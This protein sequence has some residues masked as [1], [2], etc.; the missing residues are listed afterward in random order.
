MVVCLSSMHEEQVLNTK[1]ESCSKLS[2][3]PFPF[4]YSARKGVMTD[5]V[6]QGEKQLRVEARGDFHS[7]GWPRLGLILGRVFG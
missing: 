1:A 7:P 3:F 6:L 2:D 4:Y 5:V